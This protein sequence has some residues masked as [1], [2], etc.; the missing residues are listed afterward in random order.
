MATAPTLAGAA[1]W[2]FDLDNTLYPA[3]SRLFDQVDKNITR[4]IAD[5]LGLEWAE[6]YRVQKTY[7]REH[8]TTMRGLMDRHG[9]DPNYFLEYVHDIDLSPIAPSPTLDTALGR[10]GGRK[11]VFTNGSS[12][13][14]ERVTQR[15]G[16]RRHFE[17]IFDIVDSDYRPKPEPAVYDRLVERHTIDPQNAVMVE[18]IARN[19]APAAALGMATVWVRTD[20]PWGYEESDADHVHHVVDDLVEWLT[21]LTGG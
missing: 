8:G 2:V 20:S 19:L 10:L 15:L 4:F 3:S 5:N 12:E 21:G 11:I 18:D 6:A 14:A 16:V 9:T 13:H 7:F 17:A 1:T